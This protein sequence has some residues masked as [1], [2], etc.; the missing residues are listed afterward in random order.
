MRVPIRP[1]GQGGPSIRVSVGGHLGRSITADDVT[2][3]LDDAVAEHGVP[4]LLRRDNGPEFIAVAVRDWRRFSGVGTSFIEPGSPWQ[5]SAQRARL[6]DA[7]CV[8][9]RADGGN[10]NDNVTL[11]RRRRRHQSRVVVRPTGACNALD[12]TCNTWP[13]HAV[14]GTIQ[15]QVALPLEGVPSARCELSQRVDRQSRSGHRRRGT[16]RAAT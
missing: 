13:V 15:D 4:E 12:M 5:P 7:G 11:H 10:A 8:R 2:T 9:G 16:R 14:A 1:E 6:D 3:I